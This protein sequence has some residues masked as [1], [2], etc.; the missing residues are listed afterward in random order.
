MKYDSETSNKKQAFKISILMI[1]IVTILMA[2]SG[3]STALP[4]YGT[5]TYDGY[6]PDKQQVLLINNSDNVIAGLWE[7]NNSGVYYYNNSSTS[8]VNE[9]GVNNKTIAIQRAV[10]NSTAENGTII[11]GDGLYNGSLKIDNPNV[12][13]LT[14]NNSK[15]V[16]DGLNTGS[17][18]SI[19]VDNVNVSGFNITNS[20]NTLVNV[21]N[22]NYINLTNNNITDNSKGVILQKSNN[23]NVK[24][25]Y[26]INNGG[27]GFD[28]AICLESSNKTNVSSNIFKENYICI[29]SF[30]SNYNNLVNNT[31]L[32]NLAT[33]Y[34][35]NSE[36]NNITNNYIANNSLGIGLLGTSSKNNVTGNK[37]INTTYDDTVDTSGVGILISGNSENNKVNGNKINNSSVTGIS[38]DQNSNGNAPSNNLIYNNYL[39]NTNNAYVNDSCTGNNWN[40]SKKSGTNI[41]GGPY[42]GGNY[43]ANRSGDGFSQ[44]NIDENGDG[45]CDSSYTINSNT[46]S[47]DNLPLNASYT[48]SNNYA[49]GDGTEDKPYQ[50]DNWYH[51]NN[52]RENLD[53]NF[54]LVN[55]LNE[56][57]DGYEEVVENSA[58]GFEPIGN[59]S[60]DNPFTGTFDGNGYNISNLVINRLGENN[61]GLFG[62]TDGNSISNV[63]LKDVNITGDSAV[64]ALVG[65]NNDGFVYQSYSTGNVTGSEKVGGLVGYINESNVTKSYSIAN[66]TGFS[67]TSGFVGYSS[68]NISN[69]Y[70]IGTVESTI[71][72]VSVWSSSGPDSHSVSHTGVFDNGI[73]FNWDSNNYESSWEYRTTSQE[74]TELEF[75]WDAS[76]HH[77]YNDASAKAYI[78]V[79]TPEGESR[80]N[81]MNLDTYG[82]W[83]DSGIETITVYKGKD[84]GIDIEGSHF[85]SMQEMNGRFSAMFM[86][87]GLIGYNDEGTVDNSY[88]D[89]ETSGQSSSDGGVA[90]TTAKMKGEAAKNN[91]NGFDFGSTWDVLD[92]SNISYPYLVDNNQEPEPGLQ[93][94]YADGDGTE[95]N[96][97]EIA[98]WY[99][100]NNT[101]ENLD[102]NFTLVNDLNETTDGYDSV[103]NETANGGAGFEPIGIGDD[104]NQFTGTFDGQNHKITELH[105]DRPSANKVGLFAEI[106]GNSKVSNVGLENINVTGDYAYAYVGGL[107]GHSYGTV[108]QSYSTGNVTGSGYSVGG[109]VGWNDGG[110]VNQ[111]Y[112]TSNVTG[113]GSSSVGGLV[114][115]NYGS[116]DQSYSTGNVTGSSDYVGGLV[117]LNNSGSTDNSYWDTETS[118]QDNS[119]GSSIGL[120]TAE[121][122]GNNAE[123]NLDGFDFTNTWNVIDNSKM[124]Y[125]YLLDNTQEPAPG[126]QPSYADGNGTE[127]NPYKIANWYHLNN[128]R[129]NLDA[130]FTLISDLD[131]NTKGYDEVASASANGDNGFKPIGNSTTRFTG[132]FDGQNHTIAGL[133]IDRPSASNVG[134]FGFTN[135]SEI[136]NVGLEDTN[137]TGAKLVGGLVGWND[138][139]T[140]NHSYSTGDVNGSKDVGGL[141][142]Y[143]YQ[144]TVNHSYSTGDVNGSDNVGGLVGEYNV[145]TVDHVGTV[146]Q[147]YSTG[148]VSGSE[149]VGGLAGINKGA[150][151]LQSSASGT[152]TVHDGAS[153]PENFGGLIG[154]NIGHIELSNATGDVNAEGATYVGGLVGYNLASE[155]KTVSESYA[156]GDISG[157]EYVG[158]LVGQNENDFV[159]DSY[160]TGDVSGE[161][162]L[163]GLVGRNKRG[164]IDNSSAMGKVE[165]VDTVSNKV[166][167][168]GQ[169]PSGF[170]GLVG[171]NL[172]G[173][174]KTSNAT[175]DITAPE[176][177]NVGGL[178]GYNSKGLTTVKQSYATGSVEGNEN[179]GGL[180]GWNE[181]DLV[182]NTYA[183]GDVDGDKNVGGLV[184]LNSPGTVNLSYSTGEVTTEGSTIGGLIGTNENDATVEDAYWDTDTTG[185]TSSDGGTALT[186]SEMVGNAAMDNMALDFEN[187]WSVDSGS[188]E[189]YPYLQNNTHIIVPETPPK[190]ESDDQETDSSG[191]VSVGQ[192]MPNENVLSSD[193]KQKVVSVGK[194]TEYDF[195][196]QSDSVKG[197]SF[198]S[199]ENMGRVVAKVE[200]LET[201]PDDVKS[202]TETDESDT[203]DGAEQSKTRTYSKMSITVGSEGTVSDDNSD[204][205]LIEFEVTKEWVEEN[206]I[207]VDSIRLARYHSGEWHDL[208]TNKKAE[209]DELLHFTATTPGFSVFTVVGDEI[210]T[211]EE[212]KTEPEPETEPKPDTEQNE[213]EESE[214]TPGFSSLLALGVLGAV[215]M[216]LR[217]QN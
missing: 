69:S 28:Y 167:T 132:T 32:N 100:L 157:Y 40:I 87:K 170:G 143:N 130:N 178:I 149:D 140:V 113:S 51:L 125:P 52:T 60:N 133:Q 103:A 25:N 172:G 30:N 89:T 64:G 169:L 150:T 154:F 124:S 161:R 209:D 71:N 160:A 185:Q 180:I 120:T 8:W 146:Y 188:K 23:S 34:N 195:D 14:Y 48:V 47:V 134:L 119:A 12:T 99:H 35:R 27:D 77:S 66:V 137:V 6:T 91:M 33:I 97:Y 179:V 142:G 147:S 163:G 29:C 110:T 11:V 151:I 164:T 9:S 39:N 86:N 26:F 90:L 62:Y 177:N 73:D 7:G 10:D 3:M 36:S 158:G 156:T 37:I 210:E 215:Y 72:R 17:T 193:S 191:R 61:V 104:N 117:G 214:S 127:S 107:V 182:T 123:T 4:D 84:F 20:S 213:S 18:I 109:L 217:R 21:S 128:T 63:S 181:Y 152:V 197:I 78:V 118:G 131:K 44:T 83:S 115:W 202:P 38:L 145:G 98:T 22:A 176:R 92:S 101:R 121:M 153:S 187:T 166:E 190:D 141:V 206:N 162:N 194:T 116:I 31:F 200:T 199:K 112:S 148:N 88:W 106:G 198:E 207:D 1:S 136:N 54:T 94:L 189:S 216:V 74:T 183:L 173:T 196:E 65:Y 171:F 15:P 155:P 102:A 70:S 212:E 46:D 111:S 165:T 129:E 76:G 42:L 68:G 59:D 19:S 135:S 79:D 204:N 41:M 105:I 95:G 184:G 57:T 50:I 53:A 13:E 81:I 93:I 45:I 2:F 75:K 82:S 80:I 67:E 114:G 208:P 96:E 211:V 205:L 168:Q 186:T 55:D 175:G 16:I 144:G 139:G 43:W 24:D 138:Q 56:T 201:L 5:D 192:N 122:T 203:P 85:D 58:D 49:G 174:V 126:L 108:N 159:T